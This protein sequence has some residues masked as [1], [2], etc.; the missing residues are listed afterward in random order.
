MDAGSEP[1]P[2]A[3]SGVIIATATVRPV[4]P[5]DEEAEKPDPYLL[6][7]GLARRCIGQ[8]NPAENAKVKVTVKENELMAASSW[9]GSWLKPARIISSRRR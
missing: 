7:S 5:E 8:K 2:S 1:G 9:S 3:F 6:A 4:E